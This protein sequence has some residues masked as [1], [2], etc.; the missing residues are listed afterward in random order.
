[1][2]RIASRGRKSLRGIVKASKIRV[3]TTELIRLHRLYTSRRYWLMVEVRCPDGSLSISAS[4]KEECLT[5]HCDCGLGSLAPY[6]RLKY[7]P[8]AFIQEVLQSPWKAQH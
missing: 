5:A 7:R 6:P 4:V 1:M 3:W 2:R 8:F